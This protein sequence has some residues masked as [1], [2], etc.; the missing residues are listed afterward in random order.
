MEQQGIQKKK[1]TKEK[2]KILKER[3]KRAICACLLDSLGVN[4]IYNACIVISNRK[5]N[6]IKI[7]LCTFHN[8]PFFLLICN[9]KYNWGLPGQDKKNRDGSLTVNDT[10]AGFFSWYSLNFFKT[11]EEEKKRVL[12]LPLLCQK[13]KT[14]G[15]KEE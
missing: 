14:R 7:Y 4:L 5:R 9:L 10:N 12:E 6:I 11:R 8:F 1:G 15:Q 13:S 3:E 2:K